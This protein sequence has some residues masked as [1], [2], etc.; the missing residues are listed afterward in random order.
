MAHAKHA[1]NE[2]WWDSTLRYVAIYERMI[3]ILARSVFAL[4]IKFFLWRKSLSNWPDGLE[5]IV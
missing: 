2:G 3:E 4:N 5:V 1:R